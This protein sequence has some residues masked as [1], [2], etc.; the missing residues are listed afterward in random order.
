MWILEG[1]LGVS[2][3]IRFPLLREALYRY[4]AFVGI[5]MSLCIPFVGLSNHSSHRTTGHIVADLRVF[6]AT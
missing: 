5:V 2:R 6:R 4:L 1:S 3:L